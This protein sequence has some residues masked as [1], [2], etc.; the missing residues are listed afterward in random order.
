MLKIIF[1]NLLSNAIKFTPQEGEIHVFSSNENGIAI[2]IKD[3]GVGMDELTLNKV[4]AKQYFTTR[5]TGNEAGSGFGLMLCHDLIE[6]HNGALS[7]KSSPG[8]G[9]TFTVELPQSTA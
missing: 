8:R 9:S 6:K 2:H 7:V 1:R 5:G 4:N 3:S